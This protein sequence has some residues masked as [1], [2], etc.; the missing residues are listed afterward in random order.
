MLKFDFSIQTRE[1][2]K[3]AS[4]V[5]MGRERSD[6]ERKLFQMYRHCQILR[7]ETRSFKLGGNHLHSIERAQMEEIF[8]AEER[9]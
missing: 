1:G 3:I 8:A 7:C 4:I 9:K 5:I 2:Q 6:A